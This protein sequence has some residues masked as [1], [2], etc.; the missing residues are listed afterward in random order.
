MEFQLVEKTGNT[1]T[2]RIKDADMTLISPLLDSLSG[3]KDVENVRYVESHP[4]LDDPVLI[5]TS[6]DLQAAVEKAV[7]AMSEYFVPI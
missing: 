7:S 4:D 2:I 3:N 5:V 6:K 1:M